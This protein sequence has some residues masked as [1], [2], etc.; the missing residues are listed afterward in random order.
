MTIWNPR[1][2]GRD[3]PLY[4]R[5]AD[6][7]AEDVA[8]GLLAPGARLPT[9]R[10]L[11][12]RLGVTVGTA[13]RAYAEA[14]RRGLIGGEVGRG[15][16]VQGARAAPDGP[17]PLLHG[18]AEEMPEE[19]FDLSLNYPHDAPLAAVL[20]A[21]LRGLFGNAD[22]LTSIGR[23]QPANGM[24]AHRQAGAR[25]LARLGLEADA[26]DLLV[27]PGC[28]GGLSTTCLALCRPGEVILHEALTWPGLHATAAQLGMRSVPVAMDGDGL[29]PDALEA[30]CREHRPRLLYVM[31]TLHNP[32]GVVLAGERRRAIARAAEQHGVY[33][34]E[35]DVY[36]FLLDEPPPPIRT[37]APRHG[38]YITSL[39]KSVAP[40]LRIGYLVAPQAL[41]PKLA[42]A[43]RANVLMTSSVAAAVATEA[44]LAGAAAAAADAQREEARIRQRLARDLLADLDYRADASAFHG[45]L[46]VP[47]PW[48][49][50]QFMAELAGR[51]VQVTPGV[52]FAGPFGTAEAETHVR[53]CL[54]AVADRQ[55]LATALTI[56]ADVG[57]SGA[58]ERMPVV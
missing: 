33:V 21:G 6:A 18:A 29:I 16:F 15:T 20:G 35:D 37:F 7:L 22:L 56:V 34:V 30:A 14:E 2:D 11:A 51:G 54:C 3:G 40:G 36:G 4:R 23:Y 53:L 42:H 9:H 28:Q 32:T 55:R 31:P 25:W 43:M 10:D 58:P 44:I 47:P 45:W 57:R 13:T 17:W 1:L 5:I 50:E 8:A 41:L 26:G 24:R 27:V 49:T 38:I 19:R 52:A 12:Y 46:A 48:A 39:S